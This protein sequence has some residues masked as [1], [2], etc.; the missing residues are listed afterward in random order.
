MLLE[1]SQGGG[2]PHMGNEIRREP[3]Y[4]APV[5]T[6]TLEMVRELLEPPEV[7]EELLIPLKEAIAGNRYR[8]PAELVAQRIIESWTS[9]PLN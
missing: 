6:E 3:G 7:R 5:G 2:I 1:T 9:C 8:V 4:S